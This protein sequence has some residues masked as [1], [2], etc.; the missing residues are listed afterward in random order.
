MKE[1][2]L[3][4]LELDDGL[5][6]AHSVLGVYLHAYAWDSEQAEREQ[7]RAIELDPR[8]VTA[9]LFYGNLLR[10][11]GR[12]EEALAQYRAAAEVDP[13]DPI[14]TDMI[15]RTLLLGGRP[16]EAREHF[17]N[18][19]E[20][21]SL[22]WWPHAGLGLYHEAN[23]RWTEALEEYRRADALN[24]LVRPDIARVL[25]LADRAPEARQIVAELEAEA[26]RTGL[27]EPGVA[28]ALFALGD[29]EEALAWL[30][31]SY[32]ERHPQLRFIAGSL[33]FEALEVDPL[34]L[35]LLRRIGVRP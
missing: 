30:E 32:R 3:R 1:A 23:G 8:F 26:A 31:L 34:Y 18:A 4:A 5:A 14:F 22:F 12:V 27:H 6:E 28:S 16:E 15:G 7:L 11:H 33:R 19:L 10:S 20:L 13:L 2:A 24:G 35:D 21:D 29:R 9:R 17:H 25:A